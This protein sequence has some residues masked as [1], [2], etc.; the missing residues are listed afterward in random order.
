MTGGLQKTIGH[1]NER[2]SQCVPTRLAGKR[3]FQRR[4]SSSSRH[5]LQ[6]SH[7]VTATLLLDGACVVDRDVK[8]GILW[9]FPVFLRAA[10][11][12][13]TGSIDSTTP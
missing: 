5:R 10:R 12:S 11:A 1:Q 2:H 13:M 8:Q 7:A 9:L 3:S 6:A 4:S